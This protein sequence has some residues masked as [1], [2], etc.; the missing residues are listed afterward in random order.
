GGPRGGR[1]WSA[2]GSGGAVKRSAGE[3]G[4]VSRNRS[5]SGQARSDAELGA[6]MQVLA[7]PLQG[8]GS[9]VAIEAFTSGPIGLAAAPPQPK[10]QLLLL[11]GA[12][13]IMAAPQVFSKVEDSL[14]RLATERT[15]RRAWT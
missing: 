5:V 6:S 9:E 7:G 12:P 8:V 15:A 4:G 1:W 14:E 10:P 3:G 11:G 13:P 2:T